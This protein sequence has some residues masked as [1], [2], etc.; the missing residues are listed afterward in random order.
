MP[1]HTSIGVVRVTLGSKALMASGWRGSRSLLPCCTRL[2]ESHQ[3]TP[4]A[5]RFHVKHARR[6][7]RERRGC[8]CQMAVLSP[9]NMGLCGLPQTRIWR[10]LTAARSARPRRTVVHARRHQT[11]AGH[12]RRCRITTW[13]TVYRAMA[14]H[15]RRRR[16]TTVHP[17]HRMPA[18]YARRRRVTTVHARHR[19][20]AGYA[21]R[22][23]VT[24]VRT[25]RHRDAT[26]HSRLH[27]AT[28]GR[29]P[30]RRSRAAGTRRCGT[31]VC[32]SCSRRPPA[33]HTSRRTTLSASTGR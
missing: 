11:M 15:G 31:A 23:K 24:T 3:P 13:H 21:R 5:P 14:G 30:R 32:D 2:M 12:G 18:G 17:R 28:M 29:A 16:V 7:P 9:A 33:A 25:W 20:P 1:R 22:C 10:R 19:L 6:T 8:L 4:V 27:R 26:V